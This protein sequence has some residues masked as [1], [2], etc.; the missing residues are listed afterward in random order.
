[1][2]ASITHRGYLFIESENS[3]ES[4]ALKKWIEEN[5]KVF[6]SNIAIDRGSEENPNNQINE[7]NL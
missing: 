2:K 5:E 1:M 7:K 4:Y 6:D 3:L